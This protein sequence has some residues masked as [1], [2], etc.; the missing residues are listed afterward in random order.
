M[1]NDYCPVQHDTWSCE[2]ASQLS[3]EPA[4]ELA[5]WLLQW[6]ASDRSRKWLFSVTILSFIQI[7]SFN[8]KINVRKEISRHILQITI[9]KPKNQNVVF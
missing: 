6:M 9:F 2:R 7:I 3:T 1:R 8:T 5:K 4:C